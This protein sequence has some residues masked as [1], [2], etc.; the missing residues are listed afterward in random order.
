MLIDLTVSVFF[1]PVT[2]RLIKGIIII[3]VVVLCRGGVKIHAVCSDYLSVKKERCECTEY[4]MSESAEA[5]NRGF[6][7]L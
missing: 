6:I 1:F 5:E 4:V 2:A 7:I 3:V